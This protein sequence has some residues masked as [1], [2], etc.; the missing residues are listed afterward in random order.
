MSRVQPSIARV[1]AAC[2]AMACLAAILGT[3]GRDVHGE[4]PEARAEKPDAAEVQRREQARQMA[5]HWEQQMSKLLCSHLELLRGICG[6]L[7]RD[8]RRAIAKAGED[9]VKEVSLEM[10]EAQ[11]GGRPMRWRGVVADRAA[12]PGKPGPQTTADVAAARI[13]EAIGKAVADRVGAEQAAAFM[14]EL[15]ARSERRKRSA[16]DGCIAMLDALVVLSAAQREAVARSLSDRW[17]DDML[18]KL[19][20]VHRHQGRLIFDKAVNACIL[21]HLDESQRRVFSGPGSER[22]E[23]NVGGQWPM[24]DMLG[25]I[26]PPLPRDPWWFQ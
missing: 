21:P 8:A 5:V 6:D 20:V 25:R 17:S 11:L 19:R 23:I 18:M 15:A 7:P 4:V 2:V 14:A 26:N 22:I 16:I 13:T 10:A 1:R 3:A 9:M 24:A 12:A